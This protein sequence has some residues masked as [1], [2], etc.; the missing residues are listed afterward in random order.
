MFLWLFAH[1]IAW[2]LV[3]IGVWCAVLGGLVCFS[4]KTDDDEPDQGGFS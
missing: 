3:V 4:K 1:P 2:F